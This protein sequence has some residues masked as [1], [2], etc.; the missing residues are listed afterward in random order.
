MLDAKLIVIGGET[1][2]QEIA[3][4]LPMVIGRGS[5]ADLVIP[6]GLVSRRH[7]EI[8]EQQG[9]LFVK[10]LGSLNGT[11]VNNQR[12]EEAEALPPDQL[13]TLGT[14][15]FRAIYADRPDPAEDTASVPQSIREKETVQ[16]SLDETETIM[17]PPTDEIL[18]K[19]NTPANFPLNS[20]NGSRPTERNDSACPE[21]RT[22]LPVGRLACDDCPNSLSSLEQPGDGWNQ[23]KKIPR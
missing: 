17:L 4:N 15:T 10:D 9:Q 18:P 11:F 23:M 5:E 3:L 2:N 22:E 13:L 14:V 6:D 20:A 8:F 16:F 21:M 19:E 12:I 1:E 7:A